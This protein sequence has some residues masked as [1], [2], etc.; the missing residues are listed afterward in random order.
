[1][2]LHLQGGLLV[3]CVRAEAYLV[4]AGVARLALCRKQISQCQ[5]AWYAPLTFQVIGVVVYPLLAEGA[6]VYDTNFFL[7]RE[8]P[9][10][11]RKG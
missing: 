9:L 11:F 8:L 2:I 3:N 10:V 5:S 1:M 4:H 6:W 7:Y